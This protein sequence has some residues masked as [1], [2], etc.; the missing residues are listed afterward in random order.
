MKRPFLSEVCLLFSAEGGEVPGEARSRILGEVVER[1]GIDEA[2]LVLLDGVAGGVVAVGVNLAV[3]AD[4][5]GA[6]VGVVE[7]EGKG[8]E[9]AGVGAIDEVR[10]AEEG[11]ELAFGGGAVGF[12]SHV[13]WITLY[14]HVFSS[15][16]VPVPFVPTTTMTESIESCI[17]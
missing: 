4:A 15:L 7:G 2:V 10:E 12:I 11:V 5:L 8:G 17:P 14:R 6:L 13:C 9:D 1:I 16:Q 3:F